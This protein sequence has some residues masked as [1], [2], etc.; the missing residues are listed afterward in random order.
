MVV[1]IYTHASVNLLIE[2]LLCKVHLIIDGANEMVAVKEEN[3][4]F[5][6]APYRSQL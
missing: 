2:R 6:A 5:T 4:M 1:E 3:G